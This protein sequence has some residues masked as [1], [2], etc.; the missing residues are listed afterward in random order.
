MLKWAGRSQVPDGVA[1]TCIGDLAV[2]CPMCPLPG[3]NLPEGWE[4]APV[5]L[6]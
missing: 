6:K 1:S 4:D 5:E 2:R 3:I